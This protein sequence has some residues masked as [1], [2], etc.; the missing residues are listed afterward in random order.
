MPLVRVIAEL[1]HERNSP[2]LGHDLQHVGRVGR[3]GVDCA[4]GGEHA[5]LPLVLDI[6]QKSLA[7]G[8]DLLGRA[9]DAK[10]RVGV[11]RHPVYVPIQPNGAAAPLVSPLEPRTDLFHL[12]RRAVDLEHA[13]GVRR[14]AVDAPIRSEHTSVPLPPARHVRQIPEHDHLL[15]LRHDLQD[16]VRGVGY[17]VDGAIRAPD[18]AVPL[19]LPRRHRLRAESGHLPRHGVHLEDLVGV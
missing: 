8:V 19:V 10:H 1:T 3:Y 13:F 9:P 7:D 12:P 11:R 16:V 5:A 17:P 18:A 14:E 6:G 2:R 15:R 4:V